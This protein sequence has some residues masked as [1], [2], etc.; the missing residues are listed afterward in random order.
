[1]SSSRIYADENC[2]MNQKKIFLD[3]L[4]RKLIKKE[5]ENTTQKTNIKPKISSNNTSKDNSVIKTV[6]S[7][8]IKQ[9]KENFSDKSIIQNEKKDYIK[10]EYLLSE[11]SDSSSLENN[12]NSKLSENKSSTEKSIIPFKKKKITLSN[13]RN[14]IPINS[15]D[16]FKYNKEEYYKDYNLIKNC[17][18]DLKCSSPIHQFLP[19]CYK[20]DEKYK[21]RLFKFIKDGKFENSRS[22]TGKYFHFLN[23]ELKFNKNIINKNY[24]ITENDYFINKKKKKIFSTK[25][26][27]ISERIFYNT[28][29]INGHTLSDKKNP[30]KFGIFFDRD[31]GFEKKWQKDLKE[32]DM[33]DDVESDDETLKYANDKIY[34]DIEE[35]IENYT[36][37]HF[38]LRNLKYIKGK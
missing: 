38:R 31:I 26:I 1:M 34:E 32:T 6:K 25:K 15:K 7:N 12:H 24:F 13:I 33:D 35:G 11:D 22:A 37:N 5:S 20:N 16:N 9:L 14:K 30:I 3:N 18:S 21:I 36:H 17:Y 10:F 29:I 2:E 23:N 19:Y 28:K 8:T 4:N 27:F